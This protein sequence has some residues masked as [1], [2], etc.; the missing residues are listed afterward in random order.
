M[1]ISSMRYAALLLT[2]P[3]WLYG[4]ATTTPI[5]HLVV[6]FQENISFDHYFGTYPNAANNN[7]SEPVFKAAPNTPTVNGLSG[8]LLTANPNSTQ[9]FRLT[10]AQAVTCDEGH[11]YGAEQ[12]AYNFG[13]MNLFVE[14]VGASSA[15]CD[16]N[17]LGKKIVMGYYDG[18][19]VTAL[20]NYAQNYAMSDNS[21]ST[22]FGPST[23]GALNVIA[24]T[25]HG[26]TVNSGNTNGIVSG[27]SMIGDARPPANLDDCTTTGNT[28]VTMLGKN[29]GDLLNV[30]KITWGWFQGGF[31]P[32]SRRADGTAVF[33]ITRLSSSTPRQP[34]RTTRLPR[35]LQRSARAMTRITSTISATFSPA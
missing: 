11:S 17:G 9:P 1:R 5:Q 21:F 13:L 12:K 33:R 16:I 24:G 22:V 7:P 23:P 35:R 10:R 8:P 27:G 15:S 25:T 30:K 20:W 4:Q 19:T 14:S 29:I 34:T 32:T 26:L 28:K 2:T 6:I 18:N 31:A 3:V